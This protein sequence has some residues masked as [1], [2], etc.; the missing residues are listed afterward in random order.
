MAKMKRWGIAFRTV[1]M[2]CLSVLF[3]RACRVK[4]LRSSGSEQ[5]IGSSCP[6]L[7][8]QFGRQPYW[9]GLGWDGGIGR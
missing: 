8:R 9:F 3:L 2:S 1:V 5:P 6:M 7:K 4:V